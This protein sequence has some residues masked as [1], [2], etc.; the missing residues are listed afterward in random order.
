[1][2]LILLL[3]IP[4]IASA[5]IGVMRKRSFVEWIHAASCMGSLAVGA[6]VIWRI[7]QTESAVSWNLLRADSLSAFMIAI[8]TFVGAVSGI[9]AIGYMRLEFDE[10]RF[11]RVRLFYALFQLFIFTMLFAVTT[12]S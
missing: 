3:L 2:I 4:A 9:Y 12:D 8:V 7:C 6:M 1:M 11:P 10:S 5:L